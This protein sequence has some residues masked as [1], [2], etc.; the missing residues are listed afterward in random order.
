[1]DAAWSSVSDLLN[2]KPELQRFE[3]IKEQQ[4]D[5]ERPDVQIGLGASRLGRTVIEIN[6]ISYS[7]DGKNIIKNFSYTILR[8]D[9]VGILGPNGIGK[10]TL[11]N[12]IKMADQN[13]GG[14]IK[15]GQT[16]KIGYFTQKNMEMD[17]KLRL[18]NIVKEASTIS[19]W[20]TAHE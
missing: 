17:E 15:I 10:S 4:P 19:L 1:M 2:K 14:K 5:L 7:I 9:R 16:V 12:L 18:W 13:V 20:L 3:T 8:N 11:L 6:N